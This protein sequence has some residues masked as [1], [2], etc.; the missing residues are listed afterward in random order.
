MYRARDT[1]LDRDVAIK[2]LPEEFASDSERLARFEREAKLPASLNHPNNASIHGFEE[3]N[4]VNALVL[5]LIE[6]P[7]LAE[8]I[9]QGPIPVDE[10]IASGKQID[11]AL[12]AGHEAGVT[13]LAL[14]FVTSLFG[15]GVGG[16]GSPAGPANT[17]ILNEHPNIL[18][19]ISDDLGL[20][21]SSSYTVGIETPVTPT[22]DSLAANGLVFDNA[23]ANPMCSPTRATILTGRYGFRTGVLGPRDEISLAEIS[24]Q[25]FIDKN[26]PN[27]YSHAVVG[28]GICWHVIQRSPLT[29]ASTIPI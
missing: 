9:A 3:S 7:T 14:F 27:T 5:E 12:E 16:G 1:K 29:E 28:K 11:E 19:I 15:C 6:G 26:V 10:T 2:V 13:A 22:L 8:R 4:G 18:L 20:D 25:S 23:W 24:L 21:A 17:I